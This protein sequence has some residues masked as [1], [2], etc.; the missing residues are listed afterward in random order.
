MVQLDESV[1][2]FYELFISGII[3]CTLKKIQILVHFYFLEQLNI[4]STDRRLNIQ[5]ELY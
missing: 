2:L 1:A 4:S 5:R 3:F